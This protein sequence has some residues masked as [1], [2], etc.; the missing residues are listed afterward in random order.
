MKRKIVSFLK[1]EPVKRAVRTFGQA[2][3]GYI[4]T[5]LC[6]VDFSSGKD[7]A[8]SALI[9]LGVSAVAAGLSAVM[10]LQSHA[11]EEEV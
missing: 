6:V 5:N 2:A 8:K 7:V 11:K 3:T 4:I 1:K 9:G 10:N